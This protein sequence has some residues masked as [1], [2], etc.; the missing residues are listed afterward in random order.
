MGSQI[1]M[2]LVHELESGNYDCDCRGKVVLDVGGFQGESAV[3]FSG[4]GAGK[5]IIYE[6]VLANHKFI[7][8]NIR[9][10]HVNAEI[11]E[12]GIGER[13]EV[14]VTRYEKT[15]NCFGLSQK[16]PNEM[17]IKVRNVTDVID[18]SGADIAKFDCE[19]AEKYLVNVPTKILRKIE[20][21]LIET[22]SAEIKRQIIRKFRDSGFT[23]AKGNEES[24]ELSTIH[25]KR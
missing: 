14:V 7:K 10:N 16:G 15:D 21:Y 18:Q 13:D 6:P 25:F 24:E 5:V 1:L 12:E 20:L 19:G 11:H 17:E 8:E 23:I 2:C 3:F 22:H 4:M 9:V